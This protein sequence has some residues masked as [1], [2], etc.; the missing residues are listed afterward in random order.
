MLPP[1]LRHILGCL[2]FLGKN[3]GKK[4]N[5][6]PVKSLFET[7][8]GNPFCKTFSFLALMFQCGIISN[9]LETEHYKNNNWA[10]SMIIGLVWFLQSPRN[11]GL[12]PDITILV[13]PSVCLSVPS[14]EV[15]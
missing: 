9:Y 5:P 11:W 1:K 7:T 2:D 15:A 6:T 12:S 10:T 4:I 13:C 3:S 14:K 8:T